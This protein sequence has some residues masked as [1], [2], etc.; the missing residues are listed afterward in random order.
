MLLNSWF[1]QNS[2]IRLISLFGESIRLLHGCFYPRAQNYTSQKTN[3]MTLPQREGFL[4]LQ[5]QWKPV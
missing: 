3:N 5:K 1:P 4:N 2:D